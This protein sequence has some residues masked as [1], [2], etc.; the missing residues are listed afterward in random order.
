MKKGSIQPLMI[1]RQPT[2]MRI[3]YDTVENK[4]I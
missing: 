1:I 4:Q 2:D 3:P